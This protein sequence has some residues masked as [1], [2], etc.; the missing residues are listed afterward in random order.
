MPNHVHAVLTPKGPYTLSSILHSWK[1]FT[2]NKA[3]SILG[4]EGQSFWQRESYDHLVRDEDDFIRVCNYTLNNPVKAGLCHK[5]EEWLLSSAYVAQ[6]SSL[7]KKDLYEKSR[8]D[9]CA[10]GDWA[11]VLREL[12]K[13]VGDWME[14][15]QSEGIRG[16]D[17]VFACI[18]PA[19][20]IYSKYS[21]VVDAQEREIPLGG[22]PESLEPHK[23]GYLAYVWEAV[24]RAALE[25][26]LGT[27]EAKARN[28]A[29]G[30]L[31]EDARLTA[32]FLWTLQSTDVASVAQASSLQNDDVSNLQE[33]D[34]DEDSYSA[35]EEGEDA[36]KMPALRTLRGFSLVYD[37]AR[38]FAQ[39]LGIHLEEWEGRIIETNKGVVRLL[40]V[41]ERAGQLFGE[42]GT[43]A[44]SETVENNPEGPVQLQL[45]PER[46]ERALPE[47][48][49]R[50]K[51]HKKVALMF[52]TI[53]SRHS[54]GQQR[55]TGYTQPCYYSRM[56][57]PMPFELCLRQSRREVL[58]F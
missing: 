16:A 28:G 57:G 7:H 39:P 33:K 43:Q 26:V 22:D 35:E 20:E 41:S 36:G 31:E 5:A 56:A 45:F 9:A 23:Q 54:T 50:S 14:R 46:Q 34:D 52:L 53:H 48:K 15:L 32:L 19:L 10:T 40:Y 27:A 6:A 24:G 18:G 11:D 42:A 30:S 29:S 3:N 8:Q 12:P 51:R 44:F 58:I 17:L 47:I 13:R 55:L 25:Q 21:K 4:R 37:V 49:G 38:R 1:S 2:A